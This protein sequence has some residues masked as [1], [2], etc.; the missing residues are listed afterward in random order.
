MNNFYIVKLAVTDEHGEHFVNHSVVAPDL[1]EVEKIIARDFDDVLHYEII[2]YYIE[3]GRYRNYSDE[4]L[5]NTEM[6]I[7]YDRDG[8]P[9]HQED[10]H[11][12]DLIRKEMIRRNRPVRKFFHFYDEAY[13]EDS[14]SY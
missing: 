5:Y 10:Y 7:R 12:L 11:K 1:D 2:R 9:L 3:T 13:D 4:E 8:E 6:D 14:Y